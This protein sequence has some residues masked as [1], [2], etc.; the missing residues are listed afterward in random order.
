MQ[1]L[2]RPRTKGVM[3][4]Y[5]LV[6]PRTGETRYVGKADDTARRVRSH[7][8]ESKLLRNRRDRWIRGLVLQ[9]LKPE[10]VVLQ[11]VGPGEDWRALERLWIGLYRAA[12]CRLTNGTWGGEGCDATSETRAK[13]SASAKRRGTNEAQMVG[14]DK[15]RRNRNGSKHPMSK[16]TEIDVLYIREAK[17]SGS[18]FQK[19]MDEFGV[20]MGTLQ[21]IVYGETW[22]HVGGPISPPKK[23]LTVEQVADIRSRFGSGESKESLIQAFNVTRVTINAIISGRSRA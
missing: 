1:V 5:G 19:L 21:P 16:L 10:L 8:S 20:S 23:V 13:M 4:I 12:G 14:L 7:L 17:A 3:S 9:G 15:G 6:D 2:D 18:T 11:E 22:K